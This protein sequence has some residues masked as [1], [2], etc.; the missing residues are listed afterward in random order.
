MSDLTKEELAELEALEKEEADR[1]KAAAVAAKRQHLEALRLS[2]RMA[3]KHGTPGRDFVVLETIIGNIAL[4]RPLDVEIDGITPASE[5]PDLEKFAAAVVVE[6]ATAELQQ[7]M[8][9]HPGLCTAILK[10]ASDLLKVLREEE[11]KK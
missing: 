10:H 2:K 11:A 8:A 1:L 5:R 9:A 6:P 3:L 4:R 7:H